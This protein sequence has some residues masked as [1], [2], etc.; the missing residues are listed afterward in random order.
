MDDIRL[1]IGQPSDILGKTKEDASSN[2]PIPRDKYQD[3]IKD[4]P[5]KS[6][7][8]VKICEVM[9]SE[10]DAKNLSPLIQT[11]SVAH[12]SRVERPEGFHCFVYPRLEPTSVCVANGVMNRGHGQRNGTSLGLLTNPSSAYE[13]TMVGFEL[14]DPVVRGC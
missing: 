11:F 7:H 9:Q 5:M 12:L 6:L 8:N 1:T 4:G 14:G 10:E 3:I 2:L 13:I